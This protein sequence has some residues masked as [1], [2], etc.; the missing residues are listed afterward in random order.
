[1]HLAAK[2]QTLAYRANMVSGQFGAGQ[3]GANNSARTIL[4]DN[5]L[6]TIRRKDYNF[7][8]LENPALIQKN[9][10]IFFINLASISAILCHQISDISAIFFINPLTFQKYFF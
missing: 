1:M 7:N 9:S 5:S 3:F 2:F 10:A 6:R 8:L 4:R